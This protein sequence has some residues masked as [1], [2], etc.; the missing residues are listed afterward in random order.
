M[1]EINQFLDKMLD[2]YESI[3]QE[4]LMENLLEQEGQL[5]IAESVRSIVLIKRKWLKSGR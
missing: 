5:E 3:T 4:N 2:K 1:D